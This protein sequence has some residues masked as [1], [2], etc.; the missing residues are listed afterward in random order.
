VREGQGELIE[1]GPLM[2]DDEMPAQDPS[3]GSKKNLQKEDPNKT[4][5]R[6]DHAQPPSGEKLQPTESQQEP[7]SSERQTSTKAPDEPEQAQ[8]SDGEAASPTFVS[9][10]G[11]WC[12][13]IGSRVGGA[14]QWGFAFVYHTAVFYGEHASDLIAYIVSLFDRH[15]E[16]DRSCEIRLT[17]RSKSA[18]AQWNQGAWRVTLPKRCVECGKRAEQTFE[19]YKEIADLFWPSWCVMGGLFAAPVVWCAGSTLLA[20]AAILGGFLLGYYLQTSIGVWIQHRRCPRH[21]VHS[22]YPHLAVARDCL[23][24]TIGHANVRKKFASEVAQQA[25]MIRPIGAQAGGSE[26]G[27]GE[28]EIVEAVPVPDAGKLPGQQDIYGTAIT[29]EAEAEV[30][31]QWQNHD[32]ILGLYEVECTLR[33]SPSETVQRIWHRGWN[34]NL[35]V[36]SLNPDMLS[37]HNRKQR[38]I[39]QCHAWA[40]LDMHP[41]VVRCHY[42]REL[43]GVLRVFADH[44]E[45]DDLASWISDGRLYEGDERGPL[46]YILDIAIQLVRGLHFVCERKFAHLHIHPRGI[47]LTHDNCI[48]FEPLALAADQRIDRDDTTDEE[49]STNDHGKQIHEA[50]RTWGA[51]VAAMLTRD[52]E[53]DWNDAAAV[54]RK[55]E[56][57]SETQGKTVGGLEIPA[58]LKDLLLDIFRGR[59]EGGTVEFAE[60]EERLAQVYQGTIGINYHRPD[61]H[62]LD[63]SADILSQRALTCIDLGHPSEAE[64]LLEQAIERAP[65]PLIATYNRALIRWRNGTATDEQVIEQLERICANR[66][67]SGEAAALLARAHLERGDLAGARKARDLALTRTPD[68]SLLRYE[69]SALKL[70]EAK[71]PVDAWEGRR[72]VKAISPDGTLAA[73][74]DKHGDHWSLQ[75]VGKKGGEEWQNMKPQFPGGPCN[76]F[77]DDGK[78]ILWASKANIGVRHIVTNVDLGMLPIPDQVPPTAAVLHPDGERVLIGD[79]DGKLRLY[80]LALKE[81]E[82]T[83]EGHEK[84]IHS[85]IATPDGRGAVS[86]SEDLAIRLWNLTTGDCVRILQGHEDAICSLAANANCTRI[87]SAGNTQSLHYWNAST[88]E[89]LWSRKLPTV[90]QDKESN[91]PLHVSI[92]LDG[93]WGVSG[94][95]DG[96]VRVWNLRTGQCIRTYLGHSGPVSCVVFSTVHHH[97]ISGGVDGSIRAWPT[98]QAQRQPFA[99]CEVRRMESEVLKASRLKRLAAEYVATGAA[100]KA[101]RLI[102]RAMACQGHSQDP[103]CLALRDRIDGDRDEN[104]I[105]ELHLSLEDAEEAARGT[106]VDASTPPVLN[107]AAPAADATCLSPGNSQYAPV[108]VTVCESA[109]A[110]DTESADVTAVDP[111]AHNGASSPAADHLIDQPVDAT[112]YES[113]ET[114]GNETQ[115]P[116]ATILDAS[117]PNPESPAGA[118]ATCFLPDGSH[119]GDV[120]AT[121]YQAESPS[122]PGPHRPTEQTANMW[123]WQEGDV[124]LDLYEVKGELGQGSFGK[125]HR[126]LH[127]SWH[128]DLAVKSPRPDRFQ[129][130]ERKKDFLSEC[131]A[132]VRLGLHPHIVCCY[133]V[134]EIG[135]SPRVFAEYVKGQDLHQYVE[136]G[137]LYDQG[138][139]AALE[140]ILDIAIQYS[141]GLQFAHEQGL[142]HRDVKPANAMISDEGVVK[143]TDFGLARASVAHG[144]PAYRSPEQEQGKTLTPTTDVWS[145]GVSVLEMLIGH[146]PPSGTVAAEVLEESLECGPE[147]PQMPTIPPILADLLRT[148]F[149]ETPA[150]RPA[151][152]N[153]AQVLPQIYKAETGKAYARPKP[154]KA[155]LQAATTNNRAVSLYDLGQY[156]A[157]KATWERALRSDSQ[158]LESTFNLHVTRWWQ[159]ELSD[160]D[161]VTALESARTAHLDQTRDELLLAQFHLMRDD[162]ESAVQLMEMVA[163][164]DPDNDSLAETVRLTRERIPTS[165]RCSWVVPRM[166]GTLFCTN[167][168]ASLVVT[169]N[170]ARLILHDVEAQNKMLDF[171]F[172]GE[173]VES[174]CMTD[175]GH[176][177]IVGY[178]R[179]VMQQKTVPLIRCLNLKTGKCDSTLGGLTSPAL[180]VFVSGDGEYVVATNSDSLRIWEVA[181]GECVAY[182]PGYCHIWD[183]RN[184]ERALVREDDYTCAI[185]DLTRDRLIRVFR[186][187]EAIDSACLTRDQRYVLSRG[188][189]LRLWDMA[190]GKCIKS[191]GETLRRNKGPVSISNDG[192]FALVADGTNVILY[193]VLNGHCLRTFT[194]HEN[195][196]TAVAISSDGQR[197]I[198]SGDSVRVWD[199]RPTEKRPQLELQVSRI[200]TAQDQGQADRVFAD[201]LE[202]A[203]ARLRVGDLAGG[204][205]QL[206]LARSQSGYDRH[207]DAIELWVTLYKDFARQG[208]RGCWQLNEEELKSRTSHVDQGRTPQMPGDLSRDSNDARADDLDWV[209]EQLRPSPI[210]AHSFSVDGQRLLVSS[211]SGDHNKFEL[212]LWDAV[213][214]Q[215]LAHVTNDELSLFHEVGEVLK[216]VLVADGRFALVGDRRITVWDLEN[217]ICLQNS[218]DFCPTMG[219]RALISST[220]DRRYAIMEGPQYSI[221]VLDLVEARQ[222]H[223]LEGH[224]ARLMSLC[225]SH[226]DRILCS[227]GADGTFRLWDL[228]S[229]ECLFCHEFPEKTVCEARLS[230]D[231]QY[232]LISRDRH[233]QTWFLDWELESTPVSTLDGRAA[234]MVQ[235]FVASH[236][237]MTEKSLLGKKTTI[238]TWDTRD[239][240]ALRAALTVAGYGSVPPEHLN[241][242]LQQLTDH[243]D[244]SYQ[245]IP[246]LPNPP[247][248]LGPVLLLAQDAGKPIGRRQKRQCSYLAVI[249]PDETER[250]AAREQV[251]RAN[252]DIDFTGAEM[253]TEFAYISYAR[254]LRQTAMYALHEWATKH[255]REMQ[256]LNLQE[257]ALLQFP[258]TLN[259]HIS[260]IAYFGH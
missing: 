186:D 177:A 7:A 33:Q 75:L 128:M 104:G 64:Q 38:L 32:I 62:G 102:D 48:R 156:A 250:R 189:R 66:V 253:P 3:T 90:E 9:R 231:G 244:G 175:D 151:F 93:L 55:L 94:G 167:D 72:H 238:C 130:E 120:D 87:L 135:G 22:S 208:L 176:F 84:A 193:D 207:P 124:I 81:C 23:V 83:L 114:G 139:E 222:T 168:D 143:V 144:S 18:N 147:D 248:Q 202:Q 203:R 133:Y 4:C 216:V 211:R 206:R 260:I 200:I 227:A 52:L 254:D 76:T 196:V 116:D 150:E 159:G 31:P 21:V 249:G 107:D 47:Y 85:L 166:L 213:T 240:D 172:K 232:V 108:D 97:P 152:A 88:G 17:P 180:H 146:H 155:V 259:K 74:Q 246:K 122:A 230:L 190:T 39:D 160:F 86:G 215:R 41:N 247:P 101:W 13:R 179:K 181:S 37:D 158:H 14:V 50:V 164:Q 252:P 89:C 237:P 54:T 209:F 43:G 226:D 239:L 112:I 174:L 225:V 145:W 10:L 26:L 169:C 15:T 170:R 45:A 111:I 51:I 34:T 157:A 60:A 162:C 2:L 59:S 56:T 70:D 78:R 126:V 251:F 137:K 235:N 191:F 171:E 80:D 119:E 154:Q 223:R 233:T 109:A 61:F 35:T 121:M 118:D 28:A 192:A 123:D 125:V 49:P 195:E 82:S 73:V 217:C 57:L 258:N 153:I 79:E 185:W 105:F 142:T 110:E 11:N 182:R 141:W 140:R 44:V 187:Q 219:S 163:Q 214:K 65:N 173:A 103:E 19:E 68:D 16:R 212:H 183:A 99:F 197:G 198:S 91:D 131:E 24:I 210:L 98:P 5:D 204:A 129:S 77:C 20:I 256:D 29:P 242:L 221:A 184:P 30:P 220:F 134:R 201:S 100:W 36:W 69:F 127:R 188:S 178:G 46:R 117:P 25:H 58:E 245:F 115:P 132:W 53:E 161:V 136:S 6:R 95:Q 229:G 149:R 63:W 234:R 1:L 148:C 138:S 8:T 40:K 228:R 255:G 92:S 96:K 106:A 71:S 165:R 236:P 243:W 199:L 67:D 113:G 224:T 241:T 205:E 194:E 42:A 12:D 218:A 27:D 257:V